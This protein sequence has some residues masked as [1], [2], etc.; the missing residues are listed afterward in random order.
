MLE[1]ALSW[2]YSRLGAVFYSMVF[3]LGQIVNGRPNFDC[4]SSVYFSL[5]QS[6]HFPADLRIG[7]TDTLFGDLE[8]YGWVKLPADANGYIDTQRGDVFIWGKRGASGGGS[9]HTG[10][11]ANTNDIIHCSSGYNGIHIDNHDW[12]SGI[13]GSPELTVYRFVGKENVTN[14]PNDQDVAA[15]SFIKFDKTFVAD[16]VI[17]YNGTWQ[18]RTNE[19]CPVNFTWEDNGVPAE[20]LYE[21][22]SDGY[23]TGDQDLVGGSLYRI[24]GKFEV[25]DVGEDSGLWLAL[26]E[27]NGLKFWIDLAVATEI[28]KD[29]AG[30]PIPSAR[31]Q[32]PPPTTPPDVPPVVQ[33]PPVV[34]ETPVPDTPTT[35]EQPPTQPEQPNENQNPPVNNDPKEDNEMAFTEKDQKKLAV[36]TKNAQEFA[37]E[38]A[39]SQGVQDIV[40]GISQKTKIRVYIVGDALIGLGVLIPQAALVFGWGDVVRIVAASGLAAG[41]G[42]FLLTMFGIYNSGKK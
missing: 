17:E 23:A 41:A 3:R 4:S 30:V 28:S 14:D 6:G 40:S 2:M 7:N 12:L 8:R 22:D 42:G 25:L 27:W 39:K 15:G 21:V 35:P 33:D 29:A 5:K 37:D 31:P 34:P 9:G 20:P 26:I 16:E 18:V 38:V 24:P 32:T 10:E 36:A 13:N 19:L 11:F 1:L